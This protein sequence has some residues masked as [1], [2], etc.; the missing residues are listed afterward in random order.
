[1]SD[2]LELVVVLSGRT[3]QT[4]DKNSQHFSSESFELPKPERHLM[5]HDWCLSLHHLCNIGRPLI[6][7]NL[8]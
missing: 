6:A 4:L 5:Q 8:M 1:M 7:R 2:I 3:V